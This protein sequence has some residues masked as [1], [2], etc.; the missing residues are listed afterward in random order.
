M[1]AARSHLVPA[2]LGVLDSDADASIYLKLYCR[3]PHLGLLWLVRVR[4]CVTL[5]ESSR[6]ELYA[7]PGPMAGFQNTNEA[8]V[9]IGSGY[10]AP[11]SV[12]MAGSSREYG[13]TIRL[14]GCCRKMALATTTSQ[15]AAGH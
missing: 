6:I 3:P 14:D 13:R 1:P 8:L 11:E 9:V 15:Y 2:S 4:C 7:R 10:E 5:P 12:V